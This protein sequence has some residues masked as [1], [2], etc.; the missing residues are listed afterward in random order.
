MYESREPLQFEEE[1]LP[2]EET[3]LDANQAIKK[4]VDD[5]VQN[6]AT[7]PSPVMRQALLV[8]AMYVA[9]DFVWSATNDIVATR[10]IDLLFD[11]DLR[12]TPTESCSIRMASG[13]YRGAQVSVGAEVATCFGH[14]GQGSRIPC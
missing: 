11:Q 13:V 9:E 12:R 4:K 1:V 5:L 2:G 14:H 8:L 3:L 10:I 6:W 7:A